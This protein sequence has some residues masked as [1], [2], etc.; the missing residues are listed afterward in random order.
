M[1][2]AGKRFFNLSINIKLQA[3]TLLISGAALTLVFVF[4]FSHEYFLFRQNLLDK[5]AV[6]SELVVSGSSDAMAARDHA[7]AQRI[8]QALMVA[9]DVVSAELRL[10]D[11][12]VL[13]AFER[14]DPA[15]ESLLLDWL[16]SHGLIDTRLLFRRP[17]RSEDASLGELTVLG[18]LRSVYLSM[19]D[20]LVVAGLACLLVLILALLVLQRFVR[21][22]AMPLDR[23]TRLVR[24]VIR[25]KDYSLRAAVTSRDEVGAL[26]LGVNEM[27]SQIQR[28]ESD[29]QSELLVR[30]QAEERLDQLAYYD[31]VTGLP[32]RHFFNERL[33]HALNRA[34]PFGES[35][36]LMFI[37]LDNFKIINDTLG[38]QL[39][40]NLLNRVGERL[41][42]VLRSKDL[43]FRVGGDEFAVILE[44]VRSRE[45]V[46][47]VADKLVN[48][49]NKP[50]SVEHQEIFISASI[51]V[52]L[53]PEDAA[54]PTSLLR[55]ADTAMY[56]A[57]GKGKNTYQLFQQAMKGQALNR[58]A[59]E[60][61]MR[62]ALERQEFVVHYQPQYDLLSKRV[63]GVEALVRWMHP[64]K[65]LISPAEFIPIAEETGLIVPLGEWVL[66]T[67]CAQAASWDAQGL[68]ALS[69]AVNLSGR[70]FQD[71]GLVEKV[72]QVV[73]ETGLDAQLLE[74]ELTESTVMDN[75][76][77]NLRKLTLLRAAGIRLSIDDFGTGYSSMNYL[78]RFP[79]NKLKIDRSFVDGLPDQ[80]ENLGITTA[81]IALA[82]SLK[83][84]VIAEGV[85]TQE[86]ADALLARG[87][88][89]IQGYLISRPLPAAE[90]EQFLVRTKAESPHLA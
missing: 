68:G 65:G 84:E 27:L 48:V 88:P 52:S 22:I 59:L 62:R 51:G 66:R 26:S 85:E 69:I 15:P 8:L 87:C 74:L 6:R 2:V 5:L 67:G 44:D 18:D 79:I 17:I 45:H 16:E 3:V 10:A 32:N 40:D 64:E 78:K 53:A 76:P 41:A 36:A 46:A 30:K 38:H 42:T 4:L 77:A 71:E 49:F 56:Y 86:Q 81:I 89:H 20:F 13:A 75:S 73:W 35:T 28:R 61:S 82:Q 60:N 55:N 72:I 50:L 57:K 90:L 14:P 37:D 33:I 25:E 39:G 83:L 9:P 80:P 24:A 34:L 31:T 29:L 11:G 58:L 70:Q 43:I 19:G 12:S 47:S 54:E 63:L 21:S 7:A 23:L 1:A